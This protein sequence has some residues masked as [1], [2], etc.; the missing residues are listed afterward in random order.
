VLRTGERL[1]CALPSRASFCSALEIWCAVHDLSETGARLE[2]WSEQ[3]FPKAFE[4]LLVAQR[5]TVNATCRS[6]E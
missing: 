2:V 6:K 1:A 4:L 5:L 3:R